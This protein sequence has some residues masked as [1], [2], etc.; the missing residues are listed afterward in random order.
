MTTVVRGKTI[1]IRY[2]HSY[3][4]LAELLRDALHESAQLPLARLG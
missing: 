4:R 3:E 2:G 1:R